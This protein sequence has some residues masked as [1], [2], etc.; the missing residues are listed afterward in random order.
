MGLTITF[1][2]S[3]K[4]WVRF[5]SFVPD[6]GISVANDYFTFKDGEIWKHH[7]DSVV[8]N[9]FYDDPTYQ[10]SYVEF[11]FN[12]SVEAIKSFKTINY[13][14]SQS[15]IVG[16][17]WDATE[18]T[19][20][21]NKDGWYVD[22]LSTDQQTG[23]VDDFVKKEG[24]WFN[25]IKGE[26]TYHNSSIDHNL[27]TSEFSFQGIGPSLGIS[28]VGMN[29]SC[30]LYGCT[31]PAADNYDPNADCDD[32]SCT[33]TIIGCM[34]PSANNYNS[35]ATSQPAN[36]C[37]YWGCLDPTAMNFQ[38]PPGTNYND[39]SSCLYCVYGCMDNTTPDGQGPGIPGAT[40]Y[41]PLATCDDGSCTYCTTNGCIDPNADNY[42]PAACIDDG[43]CLYTSGCTDPPAV[44]TCGACQNDCNDD[45]AGTN[46][47][48]W[49]DCCCYNSSPGCMD[50]AACNYVATACIPD[51]CDY[52]CQGCP[53]QC[54][55]TSGAWP[56]APGT[57]QG[58][59]NTSGP[60]GTWDPYDPNNLQ[61]YMTD[62]CD[63][64][65]QGCGIIGCTD[66]A[67]DWSG[68]NYDAGATCPC[69]G[70][71]SCC[72]YP[73]E[74]NGLVGCHDPSACSYDTNS[75]GCDG[76]LAIGDPAT[77][78]ADPA[79]W[80]CCDYDSCVGCTDPATVLILALVS[81]F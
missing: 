14:G 71:N 16:H 79:D 33:Y 65:N 52:S 46:A 15:R 29:P 21:L 48:G 13:E 6:H 34:D 43:S 74:C 22:L 68:G 5:K 41:N 1:N 37:Q 25:N 80:S 2:E 26:S 64:N 27:D 66:P 12:D 30:N 70:D 50:P 42:D 59:P 77:G 18:Y 69:N 61:S 55:P 73:P 39:P 49:N 7:N 76:I 47:P 20:I 67:A 8:R 31:D 75:C 17:G 23:V 60:N 63:P 36:S 11:I 35:N 54:C 72:I 9:T 28:A 56:P 32:G 40:N 4:G 24:K 45:P 62:C 3:V 38:E 57:Y 44:N 78:G 10:E 58:C 51:T 19:N 81:Y 53:L